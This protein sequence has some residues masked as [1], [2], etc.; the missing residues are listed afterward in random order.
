MCQLSD[1]VG[2][3]GG[4]TGFISLFY[5]IKQ[6][7]Y[8]R[9]KF[10]VEPD[11]INY[12]KTNEFAISNSHYNSTCSALIS[13]KITNKSAYPVTIDE[14]IG[15]SEKGRLVHD[16]NF[17]YT[18]LDI[19]NGPNRLASGLRARPIAT[20]PLRI[21]DFETK[22]IGVCFPFFADAVSQYGVPAE[23]QVVLNT[24]KKACS[25]NVSIKEYHA[26]MGYLYKI[27]DDATANGDKR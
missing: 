20:L 7:N 13:L 9:G 18:P 15:I 24:S 16:Q 12:F 17:K 8:M 27:P 1:V 2:T 3:I 4:I 23:C 21:G 14:I 26:L 11:P 25:V 19:P 10:T 5:T 22:Y 6:S